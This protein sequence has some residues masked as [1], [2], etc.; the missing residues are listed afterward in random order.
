MNEKICAKGTGLTKQ[1]AKHKTAENML[2]EL[3]KK[4]A[5]VEIFLKNNEY[6]KEQEQLENDC[7]KA[8]STNGND[9]NSKNDDLENSS[10]GNDSR[11]KNESSKND[12]LGIS[13]KH[14]TSEVSLFL[15]YLFPLLF[16]KYLPY[17]LLK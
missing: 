8:G 5:D 10:T 12:S 2:L 7:T 14:V 4:I 3:S 16:A 17:F 11:P 13:S 9:S 1:Q 15:L 6:H